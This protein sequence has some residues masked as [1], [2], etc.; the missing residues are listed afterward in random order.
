MSCGPAFLG[1]SRF[2]VPVLE[3]LALSA[4][5]PSIVVTRLDSRAGRGLRESGTP[6]ASAATALGIPVIRTA[7]VRDVG[8]LP[9]CA[10]FAVS[11]A[12][13]LWLPKE[14]LSGFPMGV[15]NVH[16]SLLPRHR[17][18]CPVERA[19]LE[20][21]ALTGVSFMLT[22]AGW[23][24]GPVIASTPTPVEA[25]ENAGQLSDRLASIAACVL[26]EV[27]EGYLSGRLRPVEQTGSPTKADKLEESESWLDWSSPADELSRRIRAFAPSPGARTRF[28]SGTLLVLSAR[29]SDR[30]LPEARMSLI[31]G[32]LFAGCSEGSMELL[33]VRPESRRSMDGRS[34][35]A[36]YRP[37]PDEALG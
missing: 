6:V 9:P 14:F 5:R 12:F 28:R 19:I 24:T 11:A 27:L 30:K 33:E 1:S 31:D 8:T 2:A 25:E 15:V 3:A 18:P 4:Y 10:S 29:I 32:A 37:L 17:G 16:P 35:F 21:D 34:F 7:R 13:G 26:P 22:D 20:G 36:G 23:D